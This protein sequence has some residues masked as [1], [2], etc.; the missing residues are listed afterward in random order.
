M[1]SKYA[2]MIALFLVALCSAQQQTSYL[3]RTLVAK[4]ESPA[5]QAAANQEVNLVKVE[6]EVE[7]GSEQQGERRLACGGLWQSCCSGSS[8]GKSLGC[9]G[10]VCEW[11]PF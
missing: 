7:A 1:I 9:L 11:T 6:S 10:G 8:C 4:I 2:I 5:I 3:R